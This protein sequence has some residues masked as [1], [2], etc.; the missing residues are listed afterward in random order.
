VALATS[1][2]GVRNTVI[3]VVAAW[4]LAALVGSWIGV[5]DT[6]PSP[7]IPLG[8][9]AVVPIAVFGL[10]YLL[11]EEFRLFV[12]SLD[13]RV[14]TAA[15]TWRV[16]GAVFLIL[17]AQGALPGVFALPAGWGD[18]AIGVTA[19]LVA[20]NWRRLFPGKIFVIW[21]V[22]GILDLVVA[23]TLGVLSSATPLGIL[24][25]DVSSRLMGQFPLSLIPTFLVPLFVIF[26]LIAL[27]RVGKETK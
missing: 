10:A 27:I 25:G 6:Q 9:F 1:T 26:H 21:N 20:W 8:L 24:R 19:P 14:L 17:W 4:F 18:V 23:V 3:G 22:L 12:L 5:F 11:S 15:Q 16:L 7:P 2:G 13:L